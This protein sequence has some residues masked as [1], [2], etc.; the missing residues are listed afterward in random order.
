M[1]SYKNEATERFGSTD[2]YKE[3]ESKTAG[4]TEA[5]FADYAEGLNAV[6]VKFARCKSKGY[7]PK[8]AEAQTLVKELQNFITKNYYTCTDEIL[9]GLGAMYFT[10]RRFKE[11]LDK[12]GEGTADFVSDAI[13]IFTK[14]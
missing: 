6:F 4:Y 12:N 5:D 1:D 9:K 10:D 8:S 2:A 11:N 14:D 7:T 13:K 3:F